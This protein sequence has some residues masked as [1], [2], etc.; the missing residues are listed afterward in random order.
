MNTIIPPTIHENEDL[1]G[2]DDAGWRLWFWLYTNHARDNI[3]FQIVSRV[4]L[5]R[6]TGKG[7]EALSSLLKGLPRVFLWDEHEGQHRVWIRSF[8]ADQWRLGPV[9]HT[10]KMFKHL[11]GLFWSL[12]EPFRVAFE[13]AYKDLA[14]GFAAMKSLEAP[15]RD[16]SRE[17]QSTTLS[18]EGLG[19][20]TTGSQVPSE[21]AVLEF[22]SSWPGDM[23]TGVPPGIPADEVLSWYRWRLTNGGPMPK[24]WREDLAIT[25]RS[26]WLKTQRTGGHVNGQRPEPAWAE[27]K[28]LEEELRTHKCNPES[29][30]FDSNHEPVDRRDYF[31]KK[32]RLTALRQCV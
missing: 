31:A 27:A 9:P 5:S 23:A 29:A 25:W 8:V 21:E 3:G 1:C 11:C 4:A 18:G 12:P 10:N 6:G 7:L 15:S 14:R 30:T 26:K 17:E 13:G 16:Y 20:E 19:G 22:A 2:L 24:K 32:K 28:R